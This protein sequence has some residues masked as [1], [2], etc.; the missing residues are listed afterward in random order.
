MGYH[1]ATSALTDGSLAW[2]D[3]LSYMGSSPSVTSAWLQSDR[4]QTNKTPDQLPLYGMHNTHS[5]SPAASTFFQGSDQ[6]LS[7]RGPPLT[8]TWEPGCSSCNA[9]MTT[10]LSPSLAQAH[11]TPGPRSYGN[12]VPHLAYGTPSSHLTHRTPGP[13][14]GRGT[15]GSRPVV[16]DDGPRI[17]IL[18]PDL[19]AIRSTESLLSRAGID[20]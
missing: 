13:C 14:P 9:S 16:E 6:P 20:F 10:R 17:S 5:P 3:D 7:M 12:P 2:G 1:E 19:I 4:M 11:E 18:H 8:L 15:T